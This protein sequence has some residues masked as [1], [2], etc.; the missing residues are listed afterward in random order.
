MVEAA[1]ACPSVPFRVIARRADWPEHLDVPDNLEVTFDTSLDYFSKCARNAR[2]SV[3]SLATNVTS[4]LT[5][6][7][8]TSL[9]GRPVVCTRTPATELY[10]PAECSEMLIELGDHAGMARCVELLWF[11]SE[12]RL[13]A[14]RAVQSHIMSIPRSRMLGVLPKSYGAQRCEILVGP[15]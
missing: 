12:R 10:Y 11:D 6:L 8:A 15:A 2:I 14:A 5:I 1:R 4:G 9:M 3:V 13:D 7:M